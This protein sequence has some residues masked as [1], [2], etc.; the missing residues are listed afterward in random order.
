[1]GIEVISTLQKE[2]ETL[3]KQC[4]IVANCEFYIGY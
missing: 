4:Q 1:M 3:K 2:V